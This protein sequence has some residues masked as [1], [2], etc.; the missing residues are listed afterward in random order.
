MK[1]DY[2]ISY[3]DSMPSFFD[4]VGDYHDVAQSAGW[5]VQIS[6]NPPWGPFSN[7]K[8]AIESLLIEWPRFEDG[9]WDTDETKPAG[10]KEEFN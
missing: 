10:K 5:Y 1:N 8:E 9:Y 7:Q 6:D 4:E 3:Y 2:L